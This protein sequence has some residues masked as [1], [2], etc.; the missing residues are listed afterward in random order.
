MYIFSIVVRNFVYSSFVEYPY[1]NLT[2]QRTN[3]SIFVNH[4]PG[5]LETIFQL[6]RGGSFIG[7]GNRSTQRKLV[8]CRKSLTNFII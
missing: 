7:G 8:T 6:Y 4:I 3:I 2:G 1:H 5:L